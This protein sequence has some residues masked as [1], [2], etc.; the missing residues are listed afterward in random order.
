MPEETQS[1]FS[2]I[3][4]HRGFLNLWINQIFVQLSYNS[5][6]FALLVWV[7]RLTESS[8]AVSALLF[9]VY[10]PAVIFGLFVGLLTDI[11]DRRKI[12]RII[13]ICMAVCFFSLV[14]LKFYYLA[15][16][17]IAF[18]I[19]VLGQFYIPAESSA[20]PLLVK[21]DQLLLA[22]SLFS[23]TLYASFLFGFGLSGPL[24]NHLGIDFVFILGG[25]FLTIAFLMSFRFPSITNAEDEQSRKLK[26]SLKTFNIPLFKEVAWVEVWKTIQLI[27]GKVVVIFS[28]FI[29][30]SVQVVIA[31]MG[32][33]IPSFFE[34]SL[35]INATDASYVLILPLGAG[36][37]L[38]GILIGRFG[39][40]VPKRMIVSLSILIGG[41]LFFSVG[42]APLVSPA[43]K[44]FPR[45]RPLPF[46]YQ[47]P[48][49]TVLAIG[50]FFLGMMMVSVVVPSQT[51]LQENT[52][53]AV[54]GK[55]FSILG[56]LMSALTL[57]PVVAVGVLAD[58]FGTAPLFIA[59]G[60]TIA[61]L[62]FMAIKPNFYFD[63]EHLPYKLRQ[64][65]GLG[66]WEK[67]S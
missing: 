66:H 67:E 18:L 62:G 63:E 10:A 15:V 29:L 26:T 21:K 60:G 1:S 24:I 4:H 39:Y 41:L 59:I 7:Y 47:V 55:V 51:V 34:K 20:I 14:I 43:I 40:R 11:T 2:D 33:L 30:A 54:R 52:P 53:E 12:I 64:F 17:L 42:A 48:L 35:Q 31:I 8:T 13:D 23:I 49:S 37:V 36:M 45:P 22:N 25:L 58:I 44:Y 16:L 28:L 61:L 38:G 6:N 46:F 32:V 3:I 5:L 57:V 27:R 56:V 50:S 9:A 19:N 65:L